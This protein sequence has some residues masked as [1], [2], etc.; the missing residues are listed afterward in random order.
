[1]G[2]STLFNA[3]T[4]AGVP[5]DNYAFCTIDPNVGVVSVPD[6][7]LDW[8]ADF[9]Q[10]KKQTPA[11][12]EFVDI[13]GLVKGA[14]KGEGLGNQFLANIR[15][16][17]AILHVL[18]CF[19]DA[20]IVHVDGSVDPVRD[21][22]VID[23]ELQLK[24]LETVENRIAKVQKQ[25]QT[26]GDKN[27]K[28]LF[29]LLCRY[30]DAL[31]QGKSCR[32][33]KPENADEEQ[34][35][36]ELFLLTN[37]PVMYVCNVDESSAKTGNQYVEQVREAVKDE[38]A[39]ILVIAAKIESDIAELESYEERQMFLE[40]MGL[41]ESG[42]VRL[43]QSAYSLLNLRTYFTAGADECRAWTINKGDKAPKAAG[44]IHTDFEKGFIRAEVI[45]YEDFV[46]LKSEAAC[47]AAGKLGVEGK[48]YVV[49]DG[50]I[51]HFLFNV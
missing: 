28:K 15:E 37:K 43:I 12:I 3:I 30:R 26:G 17:D 23:L 29:D 32:T 48:E 47:R 1:V 33:V 14:S 31:Q 38:D 11:V 27:A 19:D 39:E 6:E 40:E 8:L 18:R 24:D 4:N 46:S 22:E 34:L 35:A 5:A 7:R 51:M 42:V 45:K 50:D 25:A 49:Q 20:N 21:K 10:P 2:K 16:T 13:A 41:E 44:V 9:Y 36:K